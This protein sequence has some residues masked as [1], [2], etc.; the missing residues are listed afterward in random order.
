MDVSWLVGW[1]GRLG[2]GARW[3]C[4]RRGSRCVILE[5]GRGKR[6]KWK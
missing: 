5:K 1:G 4:W 3:L 2:K 6:R